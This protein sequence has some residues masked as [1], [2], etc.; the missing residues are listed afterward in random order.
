[1]TRHRVGTSVRAPEG[2]PVLERALVHSTFADVARARAGVR[3]GVGLSM[4][5]HGAIV[6]GL[7]LLALTQIEPVPAPPLTVRF[8]ASP[9]PPPRL[10]PLRER[11]ALPKPPPPP[12]PRLEPPA[13][14]PLRFEPA[15]PV[16]PPPRPEPL[17]ARLEP[18]PLPIKVA[19]AAPEVRVHDSAPAVAAAPSIAP[20]GA[21]AKPQIG[22]GEEPELAFL[23]HG[24]RERGAGGTT[25]GRD[26][27]SLPGSDPTSGIRRGG[28]GVPGNGGAAVG[29]EGAFTGTGLASFLGR[30]YGV[31]LM[32]ASRL[33]AR[34]SD[35]ARYALVVPQLAEA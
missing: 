24:D 22:T 10:E 19:D 11:E 35:G 8:F 15:Q 7:V 27:A 33:G 31:T 34:T 29:S 23:K 13:V 32:E 12:K 9:P 14:P 21:P 2:G 26:Q 3:R 28:S 16:A 30:K 5:V 20:I 4:A 18:D 6:A 17:P 1:M 25:A